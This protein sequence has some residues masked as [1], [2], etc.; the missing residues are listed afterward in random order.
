MNFPRIRSCI[1]SKKKKFLHVDEL[2]ENAGSD[3]GGDEHVEAEEELAAVRRRR[4]VPVPESEMNR[5]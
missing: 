1:A 2:S 3:H 5:P 4:D